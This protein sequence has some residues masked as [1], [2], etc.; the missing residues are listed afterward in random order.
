MDGFPRMIICGLKLT[1]D[2]R[3]DRTRSWNGVLVEYKK[4]SKVPV[5]CNTSVNHKDRVFFSDVRSVAQW[6]RVD[7]IWCDGHLYVR[8]L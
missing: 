4:F 6:I 1:T 5:L 3:R 7:T 2:V 8:E